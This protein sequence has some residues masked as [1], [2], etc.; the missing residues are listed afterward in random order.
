MENQQ[1]ITAIQPVVSQ[2]FI[3]IQTIANTI[4]IRAKDSL[5]MKDIN[6][7]TKIWIGLWQVKDKPGGNILDG[8]SGA[9][10]HI[11]AL[12]DDEDEFRKIAR[13]YILE[14]DLLEIS[15]EGISTMDD[16]LEYGHIDEE[17]LIQ[18]YQLDEVDSI[19]LGT[20]NAY[21]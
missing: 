6:D 17:L 19:M 16:T 9:F 20:F 12:A 5:V 10:V 21:P 18:A 3:L 4:R 1:S 8:C 11:I 2:I 14:S 13:S 7:D 15:H